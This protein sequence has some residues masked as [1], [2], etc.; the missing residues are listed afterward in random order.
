MKVTLFKSSDGAL[1]ETHEAFA[2]HEAKIK[3]LPAVDSL[4]KS[5]ADLALSEEPDLVDAA[6]IVGHADKLREILN[7][8]VIVKRGRR[9]R[10][11]TDNAPAQTPAAA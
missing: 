8:A 7:G 5:D 11:A 2:K 4:I 9:A 1:H 6:W 10:K 3:L